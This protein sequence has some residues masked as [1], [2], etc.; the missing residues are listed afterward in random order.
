MAARSGSSKSGRACRQRVSARTRS[1][2]PSVLGARPTGEIERSVRID[3]GFRQHRI[4]EDRGDLGVGPHI[5]QEG[6]L[7]LLTETPVAKKLP[8]V[9][10]AQRIG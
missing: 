9:E 10:A 5:L 3:A 2:G 8:A 6:R 7:N 4:A 1:A